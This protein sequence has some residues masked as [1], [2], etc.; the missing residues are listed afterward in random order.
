MDI[1]V[2]DPATYSLEE[3]EFFLKHLG[4]SPLAV[5]QKPLPN[6]VN[7]TAVEKG[8][9]RIYELAQLEAHQGTPWVGLDKISGSITQYLTER[10]KWQEMSRRGAPAF[11]SMHTWDGKGRPHRSG[12]GSDAG[13][14]STYFTSDGQRQPFAVPLVEVVPEAFSAPWVTE[15]APMPDACVEDSEKGIMTCPI[16]GYS[17]NWNPDSRQAYNLA[18][19]RMARHCKTSKEPRVVEF[20]FKVFGR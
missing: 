19:A 18:R 3:N 14:V 8:L 17:T 15:E 13:K 5:M 6:G 12:I 4:E 20:G 11:P 9:G 10:A 16:D 1:E 2:F 7:K